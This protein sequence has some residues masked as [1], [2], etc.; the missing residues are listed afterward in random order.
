MSPSARQGRRDPFGVV[1]VAAGSGRR[2]GAEVPK[3]FVTLAGGPLLEYAVRSALAAGPVAVVV[4]APPSHV[5]EAI[6]VVEP[7]SRE[8]GIPVQVVPGGVERGDSVLAGMR[9]LPAECEVV[10]VHDAARALAPPV[11]FR[12]VA[13]AVALDR[14][15]VVPSLPV[16][17]TIKRVDGNLVVATLDRESLRIVQT[18]QGF[19]RDVLLA[20]HATHGSLATDDAGLVERLGV[21]VRVVDGH[22]AAFKITTPEDLLRAE[23]L[24]ADAARD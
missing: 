13:A 4:A 24:V 20:A 2:L 11:L 22:P 21:P 1:V 7:L 5:D 23:R 16:V 17:D 9:W 6:E 8:H 12:M 18:P 10:L 15:A 14:P 3:A 19:R